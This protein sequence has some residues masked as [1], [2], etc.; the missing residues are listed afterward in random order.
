[1]YCLTRS[2]VCDVGEDEIDAFMPIA[3]AQER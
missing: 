1:M 3:E 2:G